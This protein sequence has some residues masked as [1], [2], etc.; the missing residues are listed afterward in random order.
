L[1]G[2]GLITTPVA[3]TRSRLVSV[4]SVDMLAAAAMTRPASQAVGTAA[5]SPTPTASHA[6]WP[7]NSAAMPPANPNAPMNPASAGSD[8]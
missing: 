1:T 4:A 7:L 6:L 8:N 3:P 2:T 5:A